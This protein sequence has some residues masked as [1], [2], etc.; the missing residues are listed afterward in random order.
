MALYALETLL[1][2]GREVHR[3][4]LVSL[5]E[6]DDADAIKRLLDLGLVAKTKPK[7]GE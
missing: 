2:G 4:E 1:L 7:S 6:K 5:D 3:G